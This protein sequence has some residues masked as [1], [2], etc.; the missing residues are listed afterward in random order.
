MIRRIRAL[1]AMAG[2]LVALAC[3]AHAQAAPA[4]VGMIAIDTP[5]D[6]NLRWT[7]RRLDENIEMLQQDRHDDEVSRAASLADVALV[8]GSAEAGNSGE[9]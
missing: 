3:S 8:R 2:I 5:S 7:R 1:G 4:I 9:N 6:G